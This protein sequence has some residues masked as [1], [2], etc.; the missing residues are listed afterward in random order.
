MTTQ[1]K[2]KPDP[3]LEQELFRLANKM[4]RRQA[5]RAVEDEGMPK[6]VAVKLIER[7][8]LKNQK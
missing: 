5:A 3:A 2:P 1:T 4:H 8:V 7:K 6:R